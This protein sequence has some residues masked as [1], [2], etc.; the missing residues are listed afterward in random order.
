MQNLALA[1]AGMLSRLA[2][3][4]DEEVELDPKIVLG[5]LLVDRTRKFLS[6][7]VEKREPVVVPRAKLREASRALRFSDLGCAID[8]RGLRFRW[9]K[10]AG[11]LLLVSQP[12]R[13][14]EVE[15]VL[16]VLIERPRPGRP[17][18]IERHEPLRRNPAWIGE[19]IADLGFV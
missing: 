8:Q 7:E 10:G 15:S 17:E 6:F 18:R 12:F 3:W 14:S 9:R 1:A 2:R 19:V 13:S 4:G 5:N 16:R 11:N